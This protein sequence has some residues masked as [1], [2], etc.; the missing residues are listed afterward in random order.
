MKVLYCIQVC[1]GDNIINHFIINVQLKIIFSCSISRKPLQSLFIANEVIILWPEIISRIYSV[2]LPELAAGLPIS[3]N[4]F[5][6]QFVAPLR[7]C[8]QLFLPLVACIWI[9]RCLCTSSSFL[10]SSGVSIYFSG[11]LWTCSSSLSPS[12]VPIQFSGPLWTCSPSL[13]SSGVSIWFSGPLWIYSSSLSPSGVSIWFSGP[14][15]TFS[16]PYHLLLVLLPTKVE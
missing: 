13:S 14:L 8:L 12:G 15:R 4:T 1:L 5:C 16:H 11:C 3:T 10:S 6:K 9:S 2:L 7:T